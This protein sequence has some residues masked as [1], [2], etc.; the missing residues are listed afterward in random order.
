[1][2]QKNK[3]LRGFK[4]LCVKLVLGAVAALVGMALM[5][6]IGGGEI[7]VAILIG[8]VPGIA[9]RS[10]KKIVAGA[11]LGLVGYTVGAQ[12]GHAVARSV[13]G[14]P[15]G[16]W[17]VTGA[18]I[19]LTSGMSRIEGKWLSPRPLAS[20]V[21]AICGLILG[22]LFGALGDLAGLLAAFSSSELAFYH[23]YIRETSLLLA[24]IFVNLGFALASGL[25]G[26]LERKA[27]GATQA[28][29]ATVG[30]AE[31]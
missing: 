27:V 1:M 19:G 5:R 28:S 14:V 12:V 23:L 6:L 7:L 8:L 13:E 20:F 15:L 10:T 22:G 29:D 11:I 31:S 18:F 3:G 2:E 16:H 26:W 25:T 17:A 30:A 4:L 21:G 9:E 24:G